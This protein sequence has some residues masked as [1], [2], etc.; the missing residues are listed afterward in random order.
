MIKTALQVV[1]PKRRKPDTRKGLMN[2]S[3]VYVPAASTDVR[4]TFNRIRAEMAK[5][6]A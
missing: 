2:P 5:G 3:F 1:Q 4:A 6:K